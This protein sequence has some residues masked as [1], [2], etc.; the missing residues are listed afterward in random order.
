MQGIVQ[1]LT[2]HAAAQSVKGDE[3]INSLN[4]GDRAKIRQTVVN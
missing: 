2:V 4:E 3:Y 1:Y